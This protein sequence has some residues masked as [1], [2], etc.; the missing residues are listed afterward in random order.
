MSSFLTK[1]FKKYISRYIPNKI[2]ILLSKKITGILFSLRNTTSIYFFDKFLISLCFKS[3]DFD[4]VK[5]II[6]SHEKDVQYAYFLERVLR[7][8][9]LEYDTYSNV[10]ERD[11]MLCFH[12]Q[13]YNDLIID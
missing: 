7:Y 9:A 10:I 6:T 4:K 3:N 13:K 5:K 2:K 12:Q 11:R 1:I 8:E